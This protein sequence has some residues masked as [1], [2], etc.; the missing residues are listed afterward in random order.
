MCS[1]IGMGG[2]DERSWNDY[3]PALL[4]PPQVAQATSLVPEWGPSC[5][6]P[7]IFGAYGKSLAC[8]REHTLRIPK[9]ATS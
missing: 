6:A 4:V 3:N 5:T 1:W 2:T 9:Q 8:S 7:N